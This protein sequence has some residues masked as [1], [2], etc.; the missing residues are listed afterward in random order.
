MSQSCPR[1]S[2]GVSQGPRRQP[3]SRP[4]P[5]HPTPPH[6]SP[7]P[8]PIP[9]RPRLRSLQS[10]PT[11]STQ[12]PIPPQIMKNRWSAT[13]HRSSRPVG[14]AASCTRW[15]ATCASWRRAAAT[16]CAAP[17]PATA[18]YCSTCGTSEM[19]GWEEKRGCR[20][21]GSRVEGLGGALSAPR[22][23]T[24]THKQAFQIPPNP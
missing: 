12:T 1:T 15:R 8:P 10:L 17:G 23:C 14:G 16:C 21:G 3:S 9:P 13:S 18:R 4:L 24:Q 19:R 5:P 2:S 11:T 7:R 6:P 22:T 20:R